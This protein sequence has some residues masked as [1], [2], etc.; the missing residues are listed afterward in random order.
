MQNSKISTKTTNKWNKNRVI[1]SPFT[2]DR[3]GLVVVTLSSSDV[4][5]SGASAKLNGVICC[6]IGTLSAGNASSLNIP[7]RANAGDMIEF[8]ANS[9]GGSASG[10]FFYNE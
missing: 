1:S 7:L 9:V 3:D 4:V 6:S 5:Y 2:A 10:T 8:E